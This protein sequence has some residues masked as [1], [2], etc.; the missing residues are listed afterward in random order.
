MLDWEE[1]LRVRLLEH[2]N[3][4]AACTGV[5]FSARKQGEAL[6]RLVMRAV[7]DT[8]PQHMKGFVGIRPSLVQFD[9]W[10][11]TRAGAK[12]LRQAAIACVV[13]AGTF[14][15]VKFTRASIDPVRDLGQNTETG[16]VHRDSFDA[17]IWHD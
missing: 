4:R 2:P 7:S 10:A 3:V 12:Q 17:N 11:E 6:P 8:H 5:D 16:F 14:S 1:A 9:C 13:E 15:G